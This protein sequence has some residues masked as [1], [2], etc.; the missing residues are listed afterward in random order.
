MDKVIFRKPIKYLKWKFMLLNAI[1]VVTT[2]CSWISE[3][4]YNS[5]P[6]VMAY[7]TMLYVDMADSAN[8]FFIPGLIVS[9]GL[10][11][12]GDALVAGRNG[13][14]H[15]VQDV[16][17]DPTLLVTPVAVLENISLSQ[18]GLLGLAIHPDFKNNRLFYLCATVWE[19]QLLVNKIELWE[20]SIDNRQAN[21]QSIVLK[22]IIEYKD[23]EI[24]NRIEDPEE[25]WLVS[26]PE[27]KA[28][29]LTL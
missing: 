17:T 5:H 14:I 3:E 21:K 15:L 13:F 11:P 8:D 25:R 27:S 23:P 18:G 24:P 12:N 9:V 29:L 4:A 20:L 26:N 6:R 19:N 16:Y 10:L 28:Y 1:F 2:A 7:E 22:E